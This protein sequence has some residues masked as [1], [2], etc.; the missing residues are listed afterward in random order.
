MLPTPDDGSFEPKRY[1]VHILLDYRVLKI[2]SLSLS[3]S[4]Y[5]C[6]C[7]H[8][9]ACMCECVSTYVCVWVRVYRYVCVYLCMYVRCAHDVTVIVVRKRTRPVDFK[10]CLCF[11]LCKCHWERHESTS[12]YPSYWCGQI[13]VFSLNKAS[14]HGEGQI[15]SSKTKECYSKNL[16]FIDT[17]LFCYQIIRKFWLV[18][19]KPWLP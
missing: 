6:V 2:F 14:D 4:I 12:T 13:L 19:L 8:A 18:L 11:T 16:W 5:L 15:L 7:A 1:S 10:S 9:R 17:P 3:L